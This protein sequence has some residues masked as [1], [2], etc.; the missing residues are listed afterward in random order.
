MYQSIKKGSLNTENMIVCTDTMHRV[1]GIMT[2]HQLLLISIISILISA[3]SFAYEFKHFTLKKSPR[4][5]VMAK[6]I[7]DD[8]RSD[9]VQRINAMIG[10]DYN[11]IGAE[12]ASPL[13]LNHDIGG[14]VLNF[15]GF[16]WNKPQAGIS[17]VANREVSPDLYSNRHIIHDTLTVNVDA[18][19][20][21]T[22]LRDSDVIDISEQSLAGFIG[23]GFQRVYHYYH[24]ADSY[25]NGITADYSKLFL[26]FTKFNVDSS[27]NMDRYEIVKKEDQFYFNA[28]GFVTTPPV[29][30]V[31]LT[32][33]VLVDVA[34][35]NQVTL[36]SM[37]PEDS[38]K[39]G[40]FLRVSNNKEWNVSARANI[41]IQLDFFHI[42]KLYL[43]QGEL[44]YTYGRSHKQNLS[45]YERD[46]ELI[47]GSSDHHKEYKSIVKGKKEDI[48][49]WKSNIVQLEDRIKQNYK[50]KY[51]VLLFGSIRKKETEQIKIIKDGI[52]TVFYKHYSQATTYIQNLLSRL[53]NIVIVKIFNFDTGVKNFAESAKKMSLEYKFLT[54]LEKEVVNTDEE[55]SLTLTHSY[56]SGKTHRW[57]DRRIKR[58][59]VEA[60][61][62]WSNLHS[63]VAKMVK[64]ETLRGPLFFESKIEIEKVGLEYFHTQSINQIFTAIVNTC[65]S[66]RLKSWLNPSKRRKMLRRV[67]FG[68][69][70]CVKKL[71]KRYLDYKA[72][73]DQY[74]RRD[75]RL[76][77]RFIGKYFSK[78]RSFRQVESIFGQNNVFIHG[79]LMAK[80]VTGIPF[81]TYFKTGQFTG[82][83]V[84][85]SFMR[86]SGTT[87]PLK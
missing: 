45:F 86:Q 11:R 76:F 20:Y 85:D 2:N 43:L 81:S 52:E 60:I 6:S 7:D 74:D 87:I 27:L 63:S 30:G 80:H 47:T 83:G 55:F 75:L 18:S 14:G 54:D 1:K 5:A 62:R 49:F 22:E 53:L 3:Q 51:S 34:F 8:V 19:T 4:H 77:R 71:G 28:G 12:Q 23:V 65:R 68:K 44:E 70:A 36:Q 82:L 15:S 39:P 59:A 72:Y 38:A 10:N 58:K 69:N 56:Q 32:T 73:F 57:I 50:S 9:L 26:A 37:G 64:N 41:S 78:T 42:L 48:H 35:K 46:V 33:G 79:S 40:E 29:S 25:V 21:L 84:I 24:F 17:L 66:K 61:T 31:S 67:Q 13:V 16:T